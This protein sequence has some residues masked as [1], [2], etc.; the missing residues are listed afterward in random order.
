MCFIA[1]EK[2]GLKRTFQKV[3]E[4]EEEDDDDDYRAQY[5]P[6]ETDATGP[7]LV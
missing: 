3:Q 7:Q 1:D 4:E 5:S 6:H 2:K